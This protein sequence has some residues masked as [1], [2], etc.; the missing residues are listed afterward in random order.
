LQAQGRPTVLTHLGE[1]VSSVAEADKVAAH[2]TELLS[3][4]TER[5]LDAQISVKLTQLGL[6]VDR[7][8]CAHH[9]LDLARSS[10]Q[11]ANYLWIDME[12]SGYVDVTLELYRRARAVSSRVGVCLQAYLHR[13]KADLD[14]LLPLGGGIR[15]VKGAYNEPPEVAMPRKK[16]VD[17]NYVALSRRALEGRRQDAFFAIGTH[18]ARLVARLQAFITERQAPRQAYEFEMLFGI[19]RSLQDRIVRGGWPLRVLISYGE[20][21]FPW[22]M[23][24][25]AERPANVLFVMKNLF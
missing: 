1:N 4:V 3:R 12:S 2:Y 17:E 7:E 16:D 24:R 10:D 8:A 14:A 9:L 21:W 15:L 5:G 25:L 18:D 19:Q 13:T 6:D 23:R 20:Y 22:Y 11:R